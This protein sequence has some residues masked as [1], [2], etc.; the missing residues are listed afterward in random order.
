MRAVN[1]D[2]LKMILFVNL[3]SIVINMFRKQNSL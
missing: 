1:N 2:I 3:H